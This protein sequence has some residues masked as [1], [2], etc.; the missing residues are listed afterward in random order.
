MDKIT[1]LKV[2]FIKT[3]KTININEIDIE[4]IVLSHKKSN[5][6]DLREYIIGYRHKGNAFPSP[7]CAKLPQMNAYA[8][9]FDKNSKYMNLLVNDKKILETYSEIWSK[10][11][12]L[13]KKEF[14]SEPVHNDKY[15]K[16]KIKIY[17]DKVYTIISSIIKYQKIMKIVHVYL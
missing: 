2:L 12:G 9:Y 14:N 10:I 17:N 3:K 8:K 11:I 7:L 13:I 15:I 5:G 16:I 1:S 4:E 6:K